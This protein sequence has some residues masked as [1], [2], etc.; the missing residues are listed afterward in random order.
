MKW[1]N[2]AEVMRTKMQGF[3]PR[4]GN[5]AFFYPLSVNQERW[6]SMRNLDPNPDS[7]KGRQN[8]PAWSECEGGAERT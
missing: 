6:C 1:K 5:C 4:C 2:P 3:E 8:C 7:V